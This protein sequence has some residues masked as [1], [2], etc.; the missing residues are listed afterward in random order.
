MR[1]ALAALALSACTLFQH[2]PSVS[3]AQQYCPI[4]VR[5]EGW[6]TLDLSD[7]CPEERRW[8]GEE[9][10]HVSQLPEGQGAFAYAHTD[11]FTTSGD[12]SFPTSSLGDADVVELAMEHVF[13]STTLDEILHPPE[14][15]TST[16]VWDRY[17][18]TIT[19]DEFDGAVTSVETTETTGGPELYIEYDQVYYQ[20][21]DG[22]RLKGEECL[23]SCGSA[24]GRHLPGGRLDDVRRVRSAGQLGLRHL[25]RP[26]GRRRPRGQPRWHGLRSRDVGLPRR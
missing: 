4:E 10:N 3:G 15:G 23:P 20:G 9:Q 22:T 16:Y 26:L 12:V 19:M 8:V 6:A 24:G 17:S 11:T 5:V 7:N 14:P 2:D 1:F 18:G 21:E 25:L 13:A